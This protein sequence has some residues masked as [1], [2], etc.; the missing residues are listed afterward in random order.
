M[1]E[2]FENLERLVNEVHNALIRMDAQSV[3]SLFAQQEACL[4]QLQLS[5]GI[6]HDSK[7]EDKERLAR[8]L[9]AL[10]RNHLLLEQA[11]KITDHYVQ[12]L[13]DASQFRSS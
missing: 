11:M 4:Q 7:R 2:S 8:L 13:R 1:T 5:G 12:D 10:Q 6:N 3:A 9:P